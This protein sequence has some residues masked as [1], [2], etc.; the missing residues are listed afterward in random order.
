[1]SI[2]IKRTPHVLTFEC[3]GES[4]RVE[5]RPTTGRQW[6]AL[7]ADAVT[8]S[9]RA[10]LG[11]WAGI[12]EENL[13]RIYGLT[14]DTGADISDLRGLDVATRAEVVNQLGVRWVAESL[15][16][17]FA[18]IAKAGAEGKAPTG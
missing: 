6:D 13:E 11:L 9:D 15:R 3:D 2:R 10:T 12:L 5:L 14:D 4:W 18:A 8:S 1:M 7:S 17:Y 16:A